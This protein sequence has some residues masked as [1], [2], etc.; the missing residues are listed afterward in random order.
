LA[1]IL[2]VFSTTQSPGH[3]P[4]APATGESLL[5]PGREKLGPRKWFLATQRHSVLVVILGHI[6][7]LRWSPDLDL[8]DSLHSSRRRWWRDTCICKLEQPTHVPFVFNEPNQEALGPILE[9]VDLYQT[10]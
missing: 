10:T 1:L 9:Q 8:F 6:A 7:I 2:H 3:F 4:R 5:W